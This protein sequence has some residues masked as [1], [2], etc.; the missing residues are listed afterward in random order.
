MGL[1]RRY[2]YND[3]LYLM[4]IRLGNEQLPKDIVRMLCCDDKGYLSSALIDK[5]VYELARSNVRNHRFII[6]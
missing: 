2:H 3:V 6:V 5:S 1:F 4:P